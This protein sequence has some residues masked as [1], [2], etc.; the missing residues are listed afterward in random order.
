MVL[1]A[2]EVTADKPDPG[3]EATARCATRVLKDPPNDVPQASA[4]DNLITFAFIVSG[5]IFGR[6]RPR[7]KFKFAELSKPFA[8]PGAIS[9]FLL[10]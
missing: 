5:R 2:N 1:P 3:S 7:R 6:C 10:K 9:L 8:L 4:L